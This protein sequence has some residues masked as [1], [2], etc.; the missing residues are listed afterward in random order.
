MCGIIGY[1]TK[2]GSAPERQRFERVVDALTH[3]GPDQRGI[4]TD[5][6]V[7]L[8]F[9]RLSIIDR[10]TGHQPMTNED[11]TLHIVF[12]GEI[13]NF[14]QL[15]AHLE[16]K[17]H[18]F[19]S[20]SDTETI[21]HLYEEEGER[22]VEQLRGMF[23]F[24]IHDRTRNALFLARDR[25]G[26]KP[27][28]YAETAS[29][30]YFASEIGALLQLADCGRDVDLEAI[31]AY[32][33]LQYPPGARTAWREVRHLPAA[34]VLW[35]RRGHSDA[36]TRYWHLD[37]AHSVYASLSEND[38]IGGFREHLE[39]SVK[40]RLIADVPLGAFLSGGIDSSV[41]VAAMRA[42]G[43]KVKT[44]CIGFAEQRF[45]ESVHARE[46]ARRLETEH[47]ELIVEPDSL[48]ALDPLIEGLAEPF[49]DQSLIPTY[50]L[51]RFA[52]QHVTVA[53]SGD[54]GDELFGGY[55]RYRHLARAE[56]LRCWG[57]AQPW[58][59]SSKILF[60]I[61]Q[62]LNPSRRRL[63]WPRSAL[64]RI[65]GLPPAEQFL[66]L[67]GCWQKRE[68][69]ALWKRPMETDLA[70]AW[71]DGALSMHPGLSGLSHWQALD[72]ETYLTDDILRKVDTASMA[73]SLECRCPLLD[74]LVAEFAAGVPDHFKVNR[75]WGAKALLKQLYPKLLPATL[76]DR[77]KKGFSMPIGAWMRKQWKEP[78][79]ASIEEP[80]ADG[81]ERWFD[82]QILRKM[83]SEHQEGRQ[84]HGQRLWT[85]LV[86]QRWAERFHPNWPV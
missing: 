52:R 64:D 68:R 1:L 5:Q 67:V 58:L 4:W 44:F 19:R 81:M 36:P 65:L 79:R 49:A 83:W 72:V 56:A 37:W 40:L 6:N 80:W 86:L 66:H 39:E 25:F 62:A 53:L 78:V 30:F 74:H 27:L 38:A 23:A 57:L 48:E 84:D 85:W 21:L 9:R 12:N 46:I 10:E 82:R 55:K 24:A 18:R 69:A 8:G 22:C 70:S 63:E 59:F 54:G 13:Y 50:Q 26:K 76:F 45:D 42:A 14:Q 73:C 33:A 60:R 43:G 2:G 61:E 11:G 28:V 17:G 71:M 7:G 32:L 75:K 35:V 15:R 29:G 20:R 41:T 34:S 31:D 51:C 77:E 16:A 3:R 47:H